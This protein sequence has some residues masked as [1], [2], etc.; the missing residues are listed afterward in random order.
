MIT[1]TPRATAMISAAPM[2]SPAPAMIPFTVPS[3]PRRPTRPTITAPT[4]NSAASSGKYQPSVIPSRDELKSLQGMTEK[5]ISP[6][7]RPT[8]HS[9]TFCLVVMGARLAAGAATETSSS[10]PGTSDLVG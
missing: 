2:K 5:I 4:M 8:I 6:K 10:E 7:V 3:S 1:V 9:T